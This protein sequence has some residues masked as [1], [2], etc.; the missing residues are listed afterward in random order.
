MFKMD[1]LSISKSSVL[2]KNIFT[3]D[4]NTARVSL[5]FSTL[6]P[7][8]QLH[9][10]QSSRNTHFV[11]NKL[12]PRLHVWLVAIKKKIRIYGGTCRRR[13]EANN[14]LKDEHLP[15]DCVC[16]WL[17][18]SLA[19]R[20]LLSEIMFCDEVPGRTDGIELRWAQRIADCVRQNAISAPYTCECLGHPK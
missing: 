19:W 1:W 17:T 9:N 7:S 2:L 12:D 15:D 4:I 18:G 8:R 10:L 16:I 13:R 11:W 5:S 20:N 6:I 3:S 14:A